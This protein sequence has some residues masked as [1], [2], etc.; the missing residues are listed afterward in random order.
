MEILECKHGIFKQTCVL[1]RELSDEVVI[2][3]KQEAL[4]MKHWQTTSFL[5]NSAHNAAFL[6]QDY[7]I[8]NAYDIEPSDMDSDEN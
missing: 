3:E 4:T 7:D 5:N 2:Q 6:D 8:D 1:C